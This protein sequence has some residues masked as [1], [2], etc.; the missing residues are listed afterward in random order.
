MA[1]TVYLLHFDRPFS[2]ARHYMGWTGGRLADRLDRHRRGDGANLLRH[3]TAAG[4]GWRM[5]RTW[6]GD[7]H[8][9]R[10]LKRQGGHS[11]KCPVCKTGIPAAPVEVVAAG[12]VAGGGRP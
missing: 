2:H 9:E 4:I 8:W 10:Q 3:V 5:S 12:G 1:G 7:R 6:E 11:R